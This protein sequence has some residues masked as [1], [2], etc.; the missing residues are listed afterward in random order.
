MTDVVM[1]ES[2][3]L[4][5]LMLPICSLKLRGHVASEAGVWVWYFLNHTAWLRE[6]VFAHSQ[7]VGAK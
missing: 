1:A 6:P 4:G 2:G 7:E 5:D 3:G